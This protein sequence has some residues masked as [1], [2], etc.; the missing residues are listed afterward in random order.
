MVAEPDV[1]TRTSL[2]F[3]FPCN[4]IQIKDWLNK[5]ELSVVFYWMDDAPQES[6]FGKANSSAAVFSLHAGT[7]ARV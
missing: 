3:C 2:S 4:L 6:K 5:N 7:L 1:A